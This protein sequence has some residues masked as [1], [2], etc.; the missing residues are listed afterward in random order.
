MFGRAEALAEALANPFELARTRFLFGERLRRA[1][2]RREA[3]QVLGS[4]AAG[5]E[6]LGARPWTERAAAELAA[7]GERRDPARDILTDLTPQELQVALAVGR[8]ATNREAAAS[9]FLTVK[10]IEFHLHNVYR[11]LEVRS[12]TELALWLGRHQAVEA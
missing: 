3:S 1:G 6:R 10:T 2:L 4:A 8:G 11:K 5:F 7:L 12:R 9:L